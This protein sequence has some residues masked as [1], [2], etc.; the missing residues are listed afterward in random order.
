[1][2][3]VLLGTLVVAMLTLTALVAYNTTFGP[4][5]SAPTA[6]TTESPSCCSQSATCPTTAVTAPCC[7]E[8]CPSKTTTVAAPCCKE[9]AATAA[10]PS[11]DAPAAETA[12]KKD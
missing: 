7:D 8:A 4:D 5:I 9:G 10:K 2:S 12:P 6:S 11:P 3:K 1:M